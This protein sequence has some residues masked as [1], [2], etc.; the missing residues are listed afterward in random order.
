MT[1]LPTSQHRPDPR[2][3]Q[4]VALDPPAGSAP[5]SSQGGVTLL[6][7]LGPHAD[8]SPCHHRPPH[9]ATPDP[10]CEPSVPPVTRYREPPRPAPAPTKPDHTRGTRPARTAWDP[11]RHKEPA[12][13]APRRDR[14]TTHYP[15]GQRQETTCRTKPRG[16]CANREPLEPTHT[17]TETRC[18]QQH[19]T[20]ARSRQIRL[21]C[22]TAQTPH[23]AHGPDPK[24]NQELTN[25]NQAPQPLTLGAWPRR[26]RLKISQ[27]PS[28]Q[29]S[30]PPNQPTPPD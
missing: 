13:A 7:T 3:T 1:K 15:A 22:I 24:L 27:S 17:P 28:P 11:T 5:A 12:Q 26:P 20:Q 18:A 25:T 30:H 21:T 23:H 9:P 16:S 4:H 6:A 19:Q 29:P 8:H 10:G 2:A 14:L